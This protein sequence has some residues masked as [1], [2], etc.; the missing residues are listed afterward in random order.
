[1]SGILNSC[2]RWEEEV[3][4]GQRDIYRGNYGRVRSAMARQVSPNMSIDELEAWHA[5]LFRN[6]VPLDY[7][8]GNVRQD[9]PDRACLAVQVEIGAIPGTRF[10]LVIAELAD[11]LN[12]FS[13]QMS[14]LEIRWP[15]LT[16]RDRATRFAIHTAY[17]VG[18][19][20][21]IHPFINGNGRI[22]RFLWN[23]SLY[24][25]GVAAQVRV[26]PRPD[27]P[28]NTV[29]QLAMSGQRAELARLILIHLASNPLSL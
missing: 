5:E 25:F 10:E 7:Y 6:L 28:Y 15:L 26:A 20:I 8:A 21:K 19:F 9:S 11:L 13:N 1:M 23:W 18:E 3:P 4:D 27:P 24:R 22:S 17:L 14:L 12:D 29:M 2:P 16:P